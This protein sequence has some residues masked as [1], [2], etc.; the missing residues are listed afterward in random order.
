MGNTL[1]PAITSKRLSI[2]DTK[3]FG[4]HKHDL[5]MTNDKY[6]ESYKAL[7]KRILEGKGKASIDE[8]HS[9]FDN[10]G[11][12]EPLS[13]LINKIALHP[14]KITNED[15]KNVISSGLDEDQIFEL[16]ICGAVGQAARQY[17]S[18][19]KALSEAQN[20]IGNEK[21]GDAA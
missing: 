11:L 18:A 15:V 19:L 14:A 5:H 20:K 10:T 21:D 4:N 12:K 2:F 7:I 1:E 16:I 17:D 6:L 13:T 8:R 9:A 3:Q